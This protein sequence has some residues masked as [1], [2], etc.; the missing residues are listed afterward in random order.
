MSALDGISIARPCGASREGMSGD[1]RVRFCQ[2]CQ[3][4]VYNLS[5]MKRED[6][7]A[8]VRSKEGRLCV[9]FFQRNDGTVLTQDCPVGLATV[10]RKVATFAAS[11]V[12]LLSVAGASILGVRAFAECRAAVAAAQIPDTDPTPRPLMGKV[13]MGDIAIDTTTARPV[14]R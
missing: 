4:N 12:G 9:R 11:F 5:G 14:T 10:K 2:L 1:E 13:R 6:A 7:E 8:L 3:L